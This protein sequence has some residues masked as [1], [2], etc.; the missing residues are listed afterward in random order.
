MS[1]QVSAS[2]RAVKRFRIAF[3][4]SSV[5]PEK[6][7]HRHKK[8]QMRLSCNVVRFCLHRCDESRKPAPLVGRLAQLVERLVY[9]EDVGSSSLSP[10]TI[11]RLTTIRY[12]HA[13]DG[14]RFRAT[15][16]RACEHETGSKA[17]AIFHLTAIRGAQTSDGAR[18]RVRCAG[19]LSA[20]KR[21]DSVRPLQSM[22][23]RRSVDGVL[24]ALTG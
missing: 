21:P 6:E 11:F 7:A 14:A 8:R 19:F 15:P 1:G 9:T 4:R 16:G 10:P 23:G 18:N 24:Q 3:V 5:R 22:I 17:F 2:H 20:K 12:A 13:S